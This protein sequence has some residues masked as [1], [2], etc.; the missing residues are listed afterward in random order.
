MARRF[1][2]QTSFGSMIDPVADK[3][4]MT[5]MTVSL[6]SAQLLPTGLVALI[7]ARDVG[8]LAGAGY[9]RYLSLPQPV[10]AFQDGGQVMVPLIYLSYCLCTSSTLM[11]FSAHGPLLMMMMMTTTTT[12]RTRSH[13]K[14]NPCGASLTSR[15]R[16][17][18]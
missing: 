2:W 6:A 16:P 11:L 4:L 12:T 7:L 15:C 1:Q 18:A 10:S 9:Y 3:T 17:C 5:V 8:L 14:R 13:A